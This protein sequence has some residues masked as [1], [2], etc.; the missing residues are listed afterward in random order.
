MADATA[1]A[2]PAAHTA[3]DDLFADAPIIHAY[4]LE[5]AIE[6]GVLVDLRAQAPELTTQHYGSGALPRIA[7][8]TGVWDLVQRAVANPR[9]GNDL[10]GVLHDVFWMARTPIAAARSKGEPG[11]AWFRVIITG[12]GR[13]SV[14]DMVADL[15]V[16]CEGGAPTGLAITFRL[17]DEN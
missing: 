5:E 17:P 9:Y 11:S 16:A 4:T 3:G 6:D 2:I 15:G 12:A 7:C 8:T 10:N 13:R 1:V 14:F